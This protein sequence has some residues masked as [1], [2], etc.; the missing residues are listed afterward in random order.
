MSFKL[1]CSLYAIPVSITSVKSTKNKES[2]TTLCAR[3]VLQS[4]KLHIRKVRI[5]AERFAL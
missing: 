1:W 4:N 3:A 5:L 2:L